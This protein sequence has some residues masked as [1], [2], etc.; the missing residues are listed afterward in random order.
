MRQV[1]DDQVVQRRGLRLRKVPPRELMEVMAERSR[2][3]SLSRIAS[4]TRANCRLYDLQS[5]MSPL[6]GAEP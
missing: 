3:S 2:F 4:M 6:D 5:G 1:I